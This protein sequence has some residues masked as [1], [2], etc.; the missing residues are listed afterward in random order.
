MRPIFEYRSIAIV[1]VSPVRYRGQ[2]GVA[3]LDAQCAEPVRS[4][5][6]MH[7]VRLCH[8]PNRCFRSIAEYPAAFV[9]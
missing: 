5:A 3:M 7:T 2:Q 8:A 1:T 9:D 4:L 6:E